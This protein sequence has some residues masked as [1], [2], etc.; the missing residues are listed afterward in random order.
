MHL[1]R[2]ELFG[3][4]TFPDKTCLEFTEGKGITAII[5]PNGCGKSNIIDAFRW[6]MGEQSIKL[7]RGTSQEEIIFAGTEDRKP[8][9]MAEVTLTIDNSDHQLKS[10]YTEVQITRRYYRSGESEYLL[11]KQV[12][13]LRDI[14][15]MLMDTGIGK[16]SYSII[17][18]GQ[19]IHIL[20]SKPEERRE[21][22]EEAAGINKYKTRKIAAQRKLQ[23]AEQNLIRLQDIRSEIH[24][25]LGPLEEQARVAKEYQV[26]KKDLAGLEIGLFK[27]KVGK[28]NQFKLELEKAIG[29]YRITVAEA[30]NKSETIMQKKQEFRAKMVELEE[31]IADLNRQILELRRSRDD[32]RN[33][34]QLSQER[35]S[36]FDH[37]IAALDIEITNLEQSKMSLVQ[38]QT[39]AELEVEATDIAVQEFQDR[40]ER[41]NEETKG[42]FERWQVIN[43]EIQDLKKQ[44]N[45]LDNQIENVKSKLMGMESSERV[46]NSDIQRIEENIAT[47]QQDQVEL[48]TKEQELKSRKSFVDTKVTDLRRVRD[49]LYQKK[50]QKEDERK[51][52]VKQRG[53]IKEKYDIRSSRLQLLL[54]MQQSHEGFQKGVKSV[55]QAKKDNVSGF[56][57][58]RGVIADV[59]TAQRQYE[60]AIEAVLD[61]ALQAVVMEDEAAVKNVISHLKSNSLGRASF[62]A[63]RV[64]AE[65]LP[66]PVKGVL[67]STV[68]TCDEQY[69]QLVNTLLGAIVIVDSLDEALVARKELFAD[70]TIKSIVTT[71]GEVV[72]R[73]GI[74]TGGSTGKDNVSLLGRQREIIESKTD[75]ENFKQEMTNIDV[76][77]KEIEQL[78]ITIENDLKN[79]ANELKGLEIEQGTIAN[80]LARIS[81]DRSKIEKSLQA[82]LQNKQEY[83]TEMARINA[84]KGN[85]NTG[86]QDFLTQKEEL[87]MQIAEKEEA[88]ASANSDKEKASELLTE[89]KVGATSAEGMRRQIE[90]KLAS[91]VESQK[92]A[93]LQVAQK[94]NEKNTILKAKTETIAAMQ[95]A[96]EQLPMLEEQINT[97]EEKVKTMTTDRARY[98]NDLE[99]YDRMD[100]EQNTSD[101]EVRASLAQEEIKLARIDTEFDEMNKRLSTEYGL[102]IE[103]VLAS[104]AVVEDYDKTS[105]EVEKLKRRIKRMEPVNLL[106]IEEYD[107]QKDR[108]AFIEKQCDD[109]DKSRNDLNSIILEL[110]QSAIA[111]FKETF[112]NVNIHFQRIF[113]E[114]FKGGSGELQIIDENNVLESGIEILAKV[115]GSK[116]AQSMMLL[117]GGQKSLTAIALLFALLSAKPG[118]FVILDEIDAEL[119]DINIGRVTEILKK[120]AQE[121]QILIITHRQSTMSVV[122]TMFGLTMETKGVSKVVSVKLGSRLKESVTA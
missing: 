112:N 104:D 6:V 106:A 105:E 64:D 33:K 15:E 81:I 75:I 85:V 97:K 54:E 2:L 71:A 38:K 11:N 88:L 110:D 98:F 3:F 77:L 56:A 22:F 46:L 115:P 16:G 79:H 9:S 5:G 19:V 70:N 93:E 83:A 86:L 36:N 13:R 35:T 101:R 55:F 120:Y 37:R 66:N 72:S 58:V 23:V 65:R 49:E 119:D 21:L 51:N 20:H 111:A 10:E 14:Q 92:N 63:E 91:F 7:L 118:P 45:G 103:D 117:S 100:K 24:Q 27:V 26:L 59:I 80:D 102:T 50:S 57:T 17:G 43:Q 109:L 47:S 94:Q 34:E 44:Q 96:H 99:V 40:L 78:F 53:E 74:I 76:V 12:A 113:G 25:Q 42:I 48:T 68:V 18:Q 73:Q 1:K 52:L 114:L 60:G 62:I 107:A 95:A 4:K 69:R 41:K 39:E 108:L 28:I 90:L 31:G 29:D 89:I 122:D 67:A 82:G 116:R 61:S 32:L 87:L 121:T 8:V 30:D 84:E